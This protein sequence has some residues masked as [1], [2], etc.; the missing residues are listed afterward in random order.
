MDQLTAVLI[1]RNEAPRLPACLASLRGAVDQVAILDTGSTD[2]TR[3]LL[4]R[5]AGSED[6][7]PPII[8]ADHPFEDFSRA[9]TASLELVET[10]YFLWID[11]D[12]RCSGPL[13]QRLADL[14]RDGRLGD[15]DLWRIRRENRV[16]GRT[17]RARHLRDQWVARLGRI[18]AVALSG[19]PVHEGLVALG[20]TPGGRLAEPLLHDALTTMSRYLRKIDH[21]TT[22]EARAGR[23]RYGALQPAHLLV[24]GPAVFWREYFWR[25]CWRDGGPGLVWA[26]LAAWSATLRS[27]K[28]L[29]RR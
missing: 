13:R 20:D 7:D 19:A 17:M 26:G 6:Q 11:A 16:L 2:G 28:V 3:E 10:P 29:T 4:T 8:W 5:L 9:R 23:S 25:G 12:E 27:W 21:Y 1:V 22:I 15:H 18:G 24:T 14:R